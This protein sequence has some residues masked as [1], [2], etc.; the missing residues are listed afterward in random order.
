MQN[1]QLIRALCQLKFALHQAQQQ[2]CDMIVDAARIQWAHVWNA[3]THTQ[4]QAFFMTL[5]LTQYADTDWT[6][7]DTATCCLRDV[8]DQWTCMPAVDRL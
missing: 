6:M 7:D 5:G 1:V 8:C 3:A 2:A 4:Q